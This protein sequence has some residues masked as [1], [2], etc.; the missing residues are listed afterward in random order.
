[1]HPQPMLW[2]Y[3]MGGGSNHIGK[4]V[5]IVILALN[6]DRR[7]C[8]KNMNG[9]NKVYTPSVQTVVHECLS[10]RTNEEKANTL[11]LDDV[12]NIDWET[13]RIFGLHSPIIEW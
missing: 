3:D 10:Q 9:L 11:T 6:A 4:I 8:M 5:T 1:M 2:K 7:Q 12:I 13:I